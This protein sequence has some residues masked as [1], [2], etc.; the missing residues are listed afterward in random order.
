MWDIWEGLTNDESSEAFKLQSDVIR[1][2]ANHSGSSVEDELKEGETV[3]LRS[4][5]ALLQI[6]TE[7]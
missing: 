3:D 1:L 7:K 2:A 5:R 4:T 6:S